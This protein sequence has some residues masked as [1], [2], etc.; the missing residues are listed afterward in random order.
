MTFTVLS[1]VLLVFV[2]CTAPYRE[3]PK[4]FVHIKVEYDSTFVPASMVDIFFQYERE[5]IDGPE[6]Y[7]DTQGDSMAVKWDSTRMG[8]YT[9]EIHS[10][11]LSSYQ[12]EYDVY[13]DTTLVVPNRFPFTLADTLTLQE[14]YD[15]DTVVCVYVSNGCFHHSVYK[16]SLLNKQDMITLDQTRS[17]ATPTNQ[18]IS[19]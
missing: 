10:A 19:A 13:S 8:H 9:I 3:A 16:V 1:V 14:L 2:I 12:V 7:Y 17:E 15:A 6:H 11:L 4:P 5:I 18:A